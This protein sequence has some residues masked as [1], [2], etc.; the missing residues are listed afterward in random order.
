MIEFKICPKSNFIQLD[1]LV[2]STGMPN[3]DAETR[4]KT[5]SERIECE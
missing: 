5:L 3:G 4:S 1:K 2:L